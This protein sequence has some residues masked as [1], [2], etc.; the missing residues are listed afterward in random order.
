[1]GA[2]IKH[3]LIFN[4]ELAPSNYGLILH[5]AVSEIAVIFFLIGQYVV[6]LIS[7]ANRPKHGHLL[8]M[9][10]NQTG[11]IFQSFSHK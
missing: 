7:K 9:S 1:M 11:G 5:Y 6:D 3:I 8:W 2:S 10:S 4:F